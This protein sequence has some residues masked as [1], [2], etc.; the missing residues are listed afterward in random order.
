MQSLLQKDLQNI[1][2]KKVGIAAVG[3]YATVAVGKYF[4]WHY[5]NSQ[6]KAMSKKIMDNRNAKTY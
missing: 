4:Q 2:M 5:K 3:L 6:L 1:T